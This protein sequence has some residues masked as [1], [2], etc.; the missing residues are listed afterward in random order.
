M[1]RRKKQ[2]GKR[3]LKCA[4]SSE[5]LI[6]FLFGITLS[7]TLSANFTIASVGFF[8]L[9]VSMNSVLKFTF[10]DTSLANATPFEICLI[11]F[12]M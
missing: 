10:I 9:S 4:K 5:K 6:G 2:P 3:L 7:P 1:P 12:S 8:A 11:N